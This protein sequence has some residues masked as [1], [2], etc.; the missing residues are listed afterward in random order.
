M[1]FYGLGGIFTSILN[2]HRVFFITALAPLFNNLLVIAAFIAYP[3]VSASDPL[4]ALIILGVGTTLGVVAQF[5]VQ[6]PAML[7]LGFKYRPRIDLHDPALKDTIKIG[8]PMVVYVVGLLISFSFRNAFALQTGGNGVGT[9]IYAWT[10]FQLPHGIMAA[11]LARALFTEMSAAFAREDISAFKHHLKSGISGTLLICIPMA[12]LMCA[13]SVPLM[14]IFRAG[15]F[16]SED[17]AYVGSILGIWIFALPFYSIQQFMFNVFSSIRHFTLFSI[18]CTA[19][20]V[21]QCSLYALLSN[22][23]VLGLTGIPITDIIYYSL[24]LLVLTIVL[25]K[26]QGSIGLKAI[27]STGIR[28][29]LAT[30]IGSLAAGAALRF[31]PLGGGMLAGIASIA[32]YGGCALLII[33]GLCHLFKVPEMSILSGFLRRA[34]K[35]LANK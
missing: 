1:L 34:R 14:Q 17:V 16:S 31:W 8:I 5:A 32:L 28:V 22:P 9:L 6:I 24:A 21:L 10:W 11:S 26:I 12:G 20:C 19:L 13:L 29:L 33:L 35:R 27:L 25:R 15:A 2:A 3:L 4:L 7:R 30:I 23:T 18:I